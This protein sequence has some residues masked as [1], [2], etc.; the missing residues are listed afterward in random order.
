MKTKILNALK[1]E[2]AN[3]GLGDKAFDG[4]AS[5]LEKTVTEEAK[6]GDAIKEEGV[7]NLLKSIQGESD[8]LRGRNAQLQKD[9]DDYKKSHPDPATPPAQTPPQTPPAETENEKKLREQVEKL[10]KRL[11]DAE[12]AS[13]QSASLAKIR[14]RLEKEGCVN[15]GI[16]NAT[17][18]GFAL[19]EG[20]TEDAAVTRLKG[21]Y[22]SAYTETFGSGPV[23]PSGG[24]GGGDPK[25]ASNAKNAWL[26]EQGLLPKE[27]TK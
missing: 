22:N 8:S 3:L 20:E 21:E 5:F 23:P 17:L 11:D 16:L 12:K 6:I 10:T 26:R 9:L 2:Y 19:G 25:A 18:K 1:T 7:K 27:E 15:K 14:E 24:I 4:V 13:S